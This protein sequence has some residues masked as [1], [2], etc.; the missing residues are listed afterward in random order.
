MRAILRLLAVLAL[1]FAN[2]HTVIVSAFDC[3]AASAL[4]SALSDEHECCAG[5]ESHAEDQS[6]GHCPCPLPCASGCSGHGLRALAGAAVVA[7]A[8]PTV[9]L[10]VAELGPEKRPPAPDR[11]GIQHVPKPFNV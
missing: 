7:V 1:V 4:Q 10:A 8:P 11:P 6:E 3:C 2:L 9:E 5:G